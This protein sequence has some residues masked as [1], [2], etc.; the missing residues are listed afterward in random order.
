M[1]RWENISCEYRFALN[2]Q[3]HLALLGELLSL[4]ASAAKRLGIKS[5]REYWHVVEEGMAYVVVLSSSRAAYFRVYSSDVKALAVAEIGD[6]VEVK[7]YR[8]LRED[9]ETLIEILPEAAEAL[10]L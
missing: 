6:C 7:V 5:A 8:A 1:K 4:I 3:N 2:A 9:T 10:G